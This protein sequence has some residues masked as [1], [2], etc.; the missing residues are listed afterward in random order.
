M[1][2]PVLS[3][4][5]L[6]V[7]NWLDLSEPLPDDAVHGLNALFEE[8]CAKPATEYLA[9]VSTNRMVQVQGGTAVCQD[10]APDFAS[11]LASRITRTPQD[12]GC[13]LVINGIVTGVGMPLHHQTEMRF[14]S[15]PEDR[16]LRL[17]T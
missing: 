12:V 7:I 5:F 13:L 11:T 14:E 16:R 4:D 2:A 3:K 15:V 8:A 9:L 6:T 10:V 1:T 17:G